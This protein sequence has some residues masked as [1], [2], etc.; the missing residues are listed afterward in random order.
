MAILSD[1]AYAFCVLSQC[2]SLGDKS[3]KNLFHFSYSLLTYA[4]QLTKVIFKIAAVKRASA[5]T[6]K[7]VMDFFLALS[8]SIRGWETCYNLFVNALAFIIYHVHMQSYNYLQINYIKR[9]LILKYHVQKLP[10]I[11]YD[12][13]RKKN[14]YVAILNKNIS[15]ALLLK[16]Q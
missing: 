3:K 8:C 4:F 11:K 13:W 15:L 16:E 9:Y 5:I 12:H 10:P 2:S 1:N 7:I 6:I 14:S